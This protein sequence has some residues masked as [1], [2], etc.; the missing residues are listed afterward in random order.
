MVFDI[1]K[2]INTNTEMCC[3]TLEESRIFSE[4]LDS[5]GRRWMS[6]SSYTELSY[7]KNGLYTFYNFNNGSYHNSLS[8]KGQR[9]KKTLYFSDFEWEKSYIKDF[10]NS[11]PLLDDYIKTFKITS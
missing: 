1:D 11:N 2:Y 9:D 6:G 8:N 10:E 4:Y 7:A 3:A 5:V